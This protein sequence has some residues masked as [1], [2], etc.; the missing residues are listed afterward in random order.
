MRTAQ[1]PDVAEYGDPGSRFKSEAVPAISEK[2]KEPMELSVRLC[3]RTMSFE[4]G[5]Q[6][7]GVKC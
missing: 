2:A 6:R 7:D 1:V 4:V 5:L 3:S